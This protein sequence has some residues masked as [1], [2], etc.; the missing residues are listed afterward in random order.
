[1]FS[2][3]QIARLLGVA[4][5]TETVARTFADIEASLGH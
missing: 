1:M 4:I 5:T 2:A 3:T